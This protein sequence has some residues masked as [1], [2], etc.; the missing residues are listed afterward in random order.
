MKRSKYLIN[1]ILLFLLANII[2]YTIKKENENMILQPVDTTMVKSKNGKLIAG[3]D[4]STKIVKK[5]K[6]IS[7][8]IE[9]F[10]VIPGDAKSAVENSIRIQKAIDYVYENGGGEVIVPDKLYYFGIISKGSDGLK[11]SA[12]T[13]KKGIKL[14]GISRERSILELVSHSDR[15]YRV[16]TMETETEIFNLT[17]KD[18]ITNNQQPSSVNIGGFD[19]TQCLVIIVG[20]SALIDGVDLYNSSTWAVSID[21]SAMNPA[22]RRDNFT[23]VN[24]RNYW[25]KRK[26]YKTIFDVSQVYSKI[27]NM[28]YENNE[29]YTDSPDF[30]RTVFDIAGSNMIIRNNTI[31]DYVQPLLISSSYWVDDEVKQQQSLVENN[32]FTGCKIG[33]LM[34]PTLDQTLKNL[35]IKDNF[36]SIDINKSAYTWDGSGVLVSGISVEPNHHGTIENLQIKGNKIEWINKKDFLTHISLISGIGLSNGQAGGYHLKDSIVSGNTIKNFP[37]LG[38]SLGSQPNTEYIT[39]NVDVTGNLFIDNGSYNNLTNG[40]NPMDALYQDFYFSH[41]LLVDKNLNNIKIEGNTIIDT[42]QTAI[43]GAYWLAELGSGTNNLNVQIGENNI[44]ENV[45]GLGTNIIRAS[46]N[47]SLNT[48]KPIYNTQSQILSFNMKSEG[49]VKYWRGKTSDIVDYAKGDILIT[50]TGLYKAEK[51]GTTGT[52]SGVSVESYINPTM[53]EV[54][55][56]AKLRPGNVITWGTV[57]NVRTARIVYVK[58]NFV[59]IEGTNVVPAHE[60]NIISFYNGLKDYNPYSLHDPIRF[61]SSIYNS[62][63]TIFN[64]DSM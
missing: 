28:R 64:M 20:H 16:I 62:H 14:R 7:V 26:W 24:S 61:L 63:P 36:I 10:G 44:E 43:K 31:K 54:N 30:S 38:L 19:N 53:M 51:Y 40:K 33:V 46:S 21:D 18:D 52:L 4:Q 47:Y 8:S 12:F 50:Q 58:G 3:A 9:D 57:G 48:G 29:F 45:I 37:T 60:G 55:D 2:G 49:T 5:V 15:Y 32:H 39:E 42:G 35:T 1:I 13:I 17:I 59:R 11:N 34:Y 25:K 6:D 41:I 22:S 27:N 23:M 56:G